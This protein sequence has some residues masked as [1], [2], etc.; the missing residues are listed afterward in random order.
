MPER[1][2][3]RLIDTPSPRAVASRHGESIDEQAFRQRVVAW[4]AAFALVD[5]HA[6]A[7]YQTD[8]L[9]FAAALLGAW[10]AGKTVWLPGDALP[11]TCRQLAAQVSA[12]AGEF[13]PDYRPLTALH[14]NPGAAPFSALD[15][16]F[17]AVVVFTSGSTGQPSAI[18]KR[19]RQLASEVATLEAMFGAALGDAE[20]VATVSHQHIYGLLFKILWPLASHRP[21][22]AH[23]LA[24][25]EEL[26]AALADRAAVL[27]AS[28]AHLKR[29]PDTLDWPRAGLRTVF[30]S[31]G[32]LPLDGVLR[33]EQLLGHTPTEIYGSSETGG[34][35]W[36]RRTG[37]LDEACS[38]FPNVTLSLADG[39]LVVASPHLADATPFV[40]ADRARFLP[41]GR[42]LLA[43]RADRIAKIEGKRVS[44]DAIEQ[45]LR[46]SGWI[47]EARV[48]ALADGREQL[49]AVVVPSTAGQAL[50]AS[51]GKPAFS[52]RLRALL[53]ESTERVALPRRW[54]F[55]DALPANAQGKTT[56]AALARLFAAPSLP[57]TRVVEQ[58]DVRL[59]LEL[60]IPGDL[61]HFDGHFIA[62]P[63]LPGVTQVDWVIHYGRQHFTIAGAFLRLEAVKFQRVIQPGRPVRLELDWRAEK[64]SLAFRLASDVGQ[65]ASGRVVFES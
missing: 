16:D 38:A 39:C 64:Q 3:R 53:A 20:V 30:S 42:F 32:P 9:E 36:R 18:P 62:S 31:G 15:A 17:P 14:G 6:V 61:I 35:A 11:A 46:A 19:L 28:P 13:P 45:A 49:A 1:L 41:D 51:D 55:V 59:V 8:G 37:G 29:L 60:G 25:P 23:S 44:L 56:E 52:R 22:L 26:A 10:Q 63:V 4:M 43:G 50:L 27:V 54:R 24:F 57:L 33:C 21:F 58:S 65:H 40:T 47:T 7:L 5:G 2:Y 34:I 12:F 48:L